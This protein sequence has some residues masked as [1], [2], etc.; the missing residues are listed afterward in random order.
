[1]VQI[2]SAQLN[3]LKS[4]IKK[5]IQRL[6][7]TCPHLPSLYKS[8]AVIWLDEAP[9]ENLKRIANLK[10]YEEILNLLKISDLIC[11]KITFAMFLRN[12][13]CAEVLGT[14]IGH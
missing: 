6:F 3:L 12:S 4:A 13:P 8:S 2:F 9:N 10:L 1:V 5:W 14:N 11:F 7:R